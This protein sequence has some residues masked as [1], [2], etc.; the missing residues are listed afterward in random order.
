[1]TNNNISLV[2]SYSRDILINLGNKVIREAAGGPML[3]LKNT[4]KD[5]GIPYNEFSGK[6]MKVEILIEGGKEF[7]RIRE[8]P[9][10]KF[11]PAT[12]VS[13]WVIISTIL[14]EWDLT[15]LKRYTGKVFVDIQGFV[16]DGSDFGKK[17]LWQGCD[18]FAP[19]IYCL[20]GTVEEM[21]YLP[22]EVYEEQKER[23]LVITDGSKSI[24][25]YDKGKIFRIPI[26]KKIESENK[27]GAGDTFLGYF[28]GA[29]FLGKQ[30]VEA[31]NFAVSKTSIF[32]KNK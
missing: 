14:N 11:F 7:G 25:L 22:K 24:K 15:G 16:R 6:E 2:S 31:A 12:K 30:P 29:M 27:I 3:F 23:L 20:K 18:K 17:K 9:S 4:L 8:E 26:A 32:L 19:K 10:I 5:M 21:S 28:I 13:S 1:M